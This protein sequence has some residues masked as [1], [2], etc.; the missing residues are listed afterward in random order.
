MELNST[1][2]QKKNYF[3]GLG[4]IE[5]SAGNSRQDKLYEADTIREENGRLKREISEM[6][7][8]LKQC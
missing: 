6:K 7:V 3:P 1:S 2:N 8:K 4:G 5:A